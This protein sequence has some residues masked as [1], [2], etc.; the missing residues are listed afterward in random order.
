MDMSVT[1]PMRNPSRM[2]FFTQ[3]LTRQPDGDFSS[4]SAART[5]PAFRASLNDWNSARCRG[6]YLAGGWSKICS[7][8]CSIC[9]CSMHLPHESDGFENVPDFFQV[10]DFRRHERETPDGLEQAH[11]GHGGFGGAGIGFD[12]IHFH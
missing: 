8:S 6:R 12:E 7:M 9:C 10:F 3:A 5:S 2:P 1:A 4:G 11:F